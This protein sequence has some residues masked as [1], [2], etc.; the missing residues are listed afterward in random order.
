MTQTRPEYVNNNSVIGGSGGLA[1]AACFVTND[2][3]FS[4]RRG[5]RPFARLN[6]PEMRLPTLAPLRSGHTKKFVPIRVENESNGVW[7]IVSR[8]RNS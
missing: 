7:T 2:F 1:P 8:V 4:F 6:E 3:S 5:D